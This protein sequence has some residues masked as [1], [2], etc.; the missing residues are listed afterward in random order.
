MVLAVLATLSCFSASA[1][2]AA[3]RAALAQ[4]GL[5]R[6]QQAP[7][8][9]VEATTIPLYQP[10][11]LAFDATGD[12]YIGDT[13]DEVIREVSVAGVI[14]TAAGNGTEGYGGDNGPAS[15]A[16]LDT[17]TGVAVDASGN[18]Y[19]ADTLNNRIR[20]V[21]GGT[22]TTIAGTG[23]PGF[24]G[25]GGPA[26][27]ATLDQPTAI[28]VD[29]NGNI[30][31]ADT[32]NN[33]IREIA[34]GTINTIAGAGLQGYSGDSGLA[35]AAALNTPTGVAVDASFN[36]YIGD[37]ENQR[38]RIVASATGNIATIAGTGVAGFNG[39]GPAAAAEL[40]G[41]S[42][43]YAISPGTV[44]VA[45]SNN[46]LIRT[47]SG[48][49]VTTIAG[50]AVQG[51]SG[52]GGASTSALLNTPGAVIA[53]GGAVFFSDTL[54]N[55]VREVTGG[56][57]NT[58]AGSP[59]TSTESLILGSAFS[60]VYGTGSLT[61]TFS[62]GGLIAT[63]AVTFYDGE[64][65][66]PATIG[67]ATLSGNAATIST[68]A[69]TVGTHYIFASYPGDAK[70]AAITSGM[71]VYIVTPASLTAVANAETTLYGQPVPGLTGT[72]AGVVAQD[73]GNVAAVFSTT[74]TSTS[75][76]GTYPITV[77]LT[78]SAASKYAVTLGTGSGSLTIAQAPTTTTLQASTT[79]PV[80]G[81]SVTLTA[82]VA[83]TTAG[84]PTGTVN[85][86]SGTTPLN[87]TP[88]TL[89]GG[90]AALTVTSLPVGAL[91]L[92]AVY[93]GNIDF[94]A[95]TSSALAPTGG[96]PDF[97]ITASPAAHSVLPSQSVNYT[98]TV[99]PLNST[100]INPV[101]FSASGLPNGVTATFNP[102]TI[103][104]GAGTSTVTMTLSASSLAQLHNDRQPFGGW[105]S[106]AALALL[107]LP[108]AFGKR[109]RRTARKLSRTGWTLM[110]LL[111]LAAAGAI[112]G[113][114]GGGFFG[115]TTQTSTVT[116]TA[117]SGPDTH[118]ATVT[119]TV[120]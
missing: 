35:T 105:P 12:L 66:S 13:N 118:T 40:D 2:N 97:T 89:S 36:V 79:S 38:V 54:N 67:Q 45:D 72:L 84:T 78:G 117:V 24:S 64:G 53:A 88:I 1:Q 46:N 22:I 85:F 51:F 92:T 34:G 80:L 49:N 94:T 101:T 76:P 106:S 7:P 57:I 8:S 107:F 108:L 11:G 60:A 90:V 98:I 68:G 96:S 86:F 74:A 59:A 58:V 29:S 71:Y 56:I 69:L 31:I 30:Y 113:C 44:Y 87:S 65:P 114:G 81:V 33:R 120:Q 55:R 3:Q 5:P 111:G 119:L 4:L 73:A 104:S 32:N 50:S 9:G 10:N 18:I 70:N 63:G 75:N 27:A 16:L 15:S 99:T 77:A 52:D 23:A 61:A 37:T 83:S 26:A 17:P 115:H 21:S 100:F 103:A 109:A 25:D 39:D 14:S 102:T 112:A 28:A 93:S 41:P 91:S 42:G 48:G 95:S 82:T 20:E 47:I 6:P 43:V 110:L 19:I 116:I 62:N